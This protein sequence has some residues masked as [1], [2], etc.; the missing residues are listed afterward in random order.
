VSERGPMGPRE[1]PLLAAVRTVT[2]ILN[3]PNL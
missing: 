1:R 3:S 2:R